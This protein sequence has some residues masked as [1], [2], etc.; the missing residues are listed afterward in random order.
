MEHGGPLL[1]GLVRRDDDRLLLQVALVD[2]LEEDVGRVLRVGEVTEFVDDQHVRIDVGLDGLAQRAA[3]C[4][5]G[6]LFD[7]VVRF[8]KHGGA[9]VLDRLVGDGDREMRLAGAGRSAQ[10]HGPALAD[11]LR[12]QSRAY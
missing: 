10:H 6:E 1:E 4:G 11:Q 7:E 9:A 3:P 8:A 12:T 2:D 5:I